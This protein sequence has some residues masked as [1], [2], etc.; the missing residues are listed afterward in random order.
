MS[1]TSPEFKC[2]KNKVPRFDPKMLA[3]LMVIQWLRNQ[4]YQ[5]IE[6]FSIR[7]ASWGGD[8]GDW[9]NVIFSYTDHTG[10]SLSFPFLQ[11]DDM[12]VSQERHEE[13]VKQARQI[14]QERQVRRAAMADRVAQLS[15]QTILETLGMCN[16]VDK[17]HKF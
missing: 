4:G 14:W 17:T 2:D 1:D 16:R 12:V 7:K 8:N 9:L 6:S 10:E 15:H 5:N 11:V 13:N 3:R